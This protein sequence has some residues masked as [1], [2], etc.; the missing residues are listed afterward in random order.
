MSPA[1]IGRM[2]SL[3]AMTGVEEKVQWFRLGPCATLRHLSSSSTSSSFMLARLYIVSPV[4]LPKIVF[5]LFK[6][7]VWSRVMKNW[8]PF[9]CGA[10]ALA[11]A[12]RP[13]RAPMPVVYN[14]SNGS[15]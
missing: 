3:E 4:T 9:V 8:L 14:R 15:Q 5:F 1:V 12:T 7:S 6:P 2:L 10:L 13:L 11:H